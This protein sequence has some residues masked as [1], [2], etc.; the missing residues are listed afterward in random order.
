MITTVLEHIGIFQLAGRFCPC[1]SRVFV[2]TVIYDWIIKGGPFL[3]FQ[4]PEIA[5]RDHRAIRSVPPG[6]HLVQT[7]LQE[8]WRFGTR[9]HCDDAAISKCD[10]FS[11]LSSVAYQ[12][13][14]GCLYSFSHS[15]R[16]GE[17]PRI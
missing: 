8:D 5:Q 1:S 9:A 17:E 2:I 3:S 6:N 7:P 14:T 11:K 10:S 13:S 12:G 4:L 16:L 15:L